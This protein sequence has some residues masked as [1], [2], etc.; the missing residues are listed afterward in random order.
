[1]STPYET[2]G[3]FTNTDWTFFIVGTL[4]IA[5]GIYVAGA[6]NKDGPLGLMIWSSANFSA[7]TLMFGLGTLGMWLSNRLD[8]GMLV[9]F[10]GDGSVDWANTIGLLTGFAFTGAVIV[11]SVMDKKS[12]LPAWVGPVVGFFGTAALFASG[13]TITVIEFYNP[14]FTSGVDW[15][16]LFPMNPFFASI[17]TTALL[18]YATATVNGIIKAQTGVFGADQ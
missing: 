12:P 15:I 14:D 9:E 5:I 4:S 17:W 7:A 6:R 3:D 16:P 10:L 18:A 1:M 8:E 11:A 2:F 13:L